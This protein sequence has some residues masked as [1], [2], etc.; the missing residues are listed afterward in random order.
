MSHGVRC[1]QSLSRPL[2]Y[3]GLEMI[4]KV[5]RGSVWVCGAAPI[6]NRLA[7]KTHS[8]GILPR[9]V[10]AWPLAP[11]LV[12]D[13]GPLPLRYTS[14]SQTNLPRSVWGAAPPQAALSLP[15]LV[16]TYR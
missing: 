6:L 13:Q 3:R 15:L 7:D 10:R 5:L 8:T 1:R 14:Q 9:I 2:G 11:R 16:S 12:F 4:I